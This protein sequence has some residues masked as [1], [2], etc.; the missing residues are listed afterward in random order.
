MMT[1]ASTIVNKPGTTPTSCATTG[2]RT[3][4][5]IEQ[6]TFLL[7]L[8]MARRADEA[9]AQSAIGH[10]AEYAW[11]S[12][13]SGTATSSKPTTA[14]C[15]R[16][17]G[18]QKGMLGEIF[19][20]AQNKIQNPATLRRLIVDLIDLEKWSLDSRREGRHLRR[21]ARQERRGRQEAQAST[22]R[23]AQLIKAIVEVMRPEP[24]ETIC[25]PACGTGGFLLAAHDYVA[26]S[27]QLDR[28][29]KKHLKFE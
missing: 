16:N 9:A 10:P 7:F 14:T 12:C 6:I 5:Y 17:S 28:D 4:D 29:Q 18:E 11:R 26:D 20:K 15:S 22:S 13:S 23:R 3:G 21:A 24:G 1:T 8:K 2:C 27:H 19:R 25:D